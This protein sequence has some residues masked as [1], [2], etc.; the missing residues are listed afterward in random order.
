MSNSEFYCNCTAGRNGIYCENKINYCQHGICLNNGVCRTLVDDYQCECLA[1]SFHGRH[2]E[3]STHRIQRLQM[4]SRSVA[5]VVIIFLISVALLVVG[6]D[7][8]KYYFGIDV[9]RKD[10]QRIRRKKRRPP[11]I[12]RFKYLNP[13]NLISSDGNDSTSGQQE[14]NVPK[15]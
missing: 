11:V 12:I 8:L 6:M 1:D 5:Y 13:P 15:Y 10:L 14:T 7:V 4:A 3:I 9:A 2:C